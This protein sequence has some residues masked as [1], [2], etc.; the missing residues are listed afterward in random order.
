MHLREKTRT[1]HL[2]TSN[3]DPYAV[4]HIFSYS[5]L[6]AQLEVIGPL[7]DMLGIAPNT[8]ASSY[9]KIR[10]DTL[11]YIDSLKWKIQ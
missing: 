5:L 3:A 1:L 6:S 4:C 10:P 11:V 9:F 7:N 8:S 2:P